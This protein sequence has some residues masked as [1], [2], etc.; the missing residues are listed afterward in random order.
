MLLRYL[1]LTV[2]LLVT[3]SFFAGSQMGAVAKPDEETRESS[4]NGFCSNSSNINRAFNR[5][6]NTRAKLV[7]PTPIVPSIAI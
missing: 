7:L 4:K 3:T 6:D 2:L 1:P 5:S